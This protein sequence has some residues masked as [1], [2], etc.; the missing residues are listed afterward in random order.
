[1]KKVS[2]SVYIRRRKGSTS[3]PLW[4]AKWRVDGRQFKRRIGP[5]W[6]A[7]G[8]PPEG[9][10]RKAEAQ[11]VLQ[12]ILTDAR[13]GIVPERSRRAKPTEG[14][15]YKDLCLDYRRYLEDER[16]RNRRT[17][18]EVWSLMRRRLIPAFEHTPLESITLRQ[19]NELTQRLRA[20]GVGPVALQRTMSLNYAVLKHAVRIEWLP[21]NP[22]EHYERVKV[23]RSDDFNVLRPEVMAVARA[24]PSESYAAL[25]VVAAFT[26]LR[27]GELRAL[28]WGDVDWSTA[29]LHVRRN[30]PCHE[31]EEKAPKSGK[32]R[33]VPL[34]DAAARV[35]DGLSQR[36]NHTGPE[37]YVFSDD[38]RPL[39][40]K[41]MSELFYEAL[42]GAG[43]SHKRTGPRSKRIVFHDLRHTF[44]TMAVQVWDVRKVQGY[45]G[46]AKLDTTMRY[47]HHVPKHSDAKALND[48]VE[49]ALG[50]SQ[51]VPESV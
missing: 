37:D 4:Y 3:G 50:A 11:Q 8:V 32:V 26:G 24:A 38:G 21:R 25:F 36:E 31:R 13:R 42:D 44:G 23:A 43:L 41:D 7:R 29:T 16:N 39:D 1:M 40:Q 5:V 17:V 15:S 12:A 45:M 28:R 6:S 47:V 14:R 35:L 20:E 18:R 19:I 34:I 48:L 46:H 51:S 10:F 22:A 9:Y 27:K 49:A 33:S 2:G 30:L